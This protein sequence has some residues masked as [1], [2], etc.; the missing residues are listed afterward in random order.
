MLHRVWISFLS[1]QKQ[2]FGDREQVR[3]RQAISNSQ[4]GLSRMGNLARLDRHP[5]KNPGQSSGALTAT[6][7]TMLATNT[8]FA[9]R[10][11][12]FQA[13]RPASARTVLGAPAFTSGT[14][15]AFRQHASQAV[16]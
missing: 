16:R 9:A 11:S 14:P 12:G 5:T 15:V 6:M 13:K 3:A 1:C 8:A 2:E 4:D 7:A 10:L